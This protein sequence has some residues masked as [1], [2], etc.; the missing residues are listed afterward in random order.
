MQSL[1]LHLIEKTLGRIDELLAEFRLAINDMTILLAPHLQEIVSEKFELALK[2][3]IIFTHC[4]DILF[5]RIDLALRLLCQVE[6][7][8]LNTKLHFHV[9]VQ[10]DAI[11][12]VLAHPSLNFVEILGI[13]EGSTGEFVE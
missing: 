3:G 2:F 12:L 13:K 7:E 10:I 9:I 11:K 1:G 6:L 8:Y 5:Q 4:C